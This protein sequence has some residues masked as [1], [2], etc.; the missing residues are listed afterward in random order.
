METKSAISDLSRT[1]AASGSVA[2]SVKDQQSKIGFGCIDLAL[3]GM[4]LIW[5]FNFIVIKTTL[6][7]IAPL[8]FMAGRFIIAATLL[9]LI[10]KWRQ[11][12]IGIPRADWRS[13][14]LLGIVG[15]TL[16]QPLF[17]NG[18]ALTKASNSALILAA[19]PAFIALLNRF[20]R[21]ERFTLR[22]WVGIALSFLGIA[23]IVVS[24][25]D[26]TLDPSAL[27]G[28]VL[29][30]TAAILWS[31]YSVLSAPLLKRYSSLS[32]T[33]LSTLFGTIPLVLLSI[34]ALAV[35]PWASVSTG[36]WVG[37]LYSAIFA[38][39]IAYVIWNI[40]VQRIGGARTA[41]YNNLTPVVAT[42]AAFVFLNETLTWL[43]IAGAVVIF[44][45][46]YLARTANIVV[47]PEA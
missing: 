39:V 4:T 24:S 14:A 6:T 17:V 32:L 27:L 12:G 23:L 47:E 45:G 44:V 2:G 34:P 46:L 8:A 11:G 28:D 19:T 40:G 43:K 37:L 15:T 5:G 29:I 1:T 31:L 13:A 21:G 41:L 10:V 3:V 26:M 22:G 9:V 42:L 16:Y 20:I 18:L 38:I 25:G 30:L 35:Q 33:A 7:E 36:G